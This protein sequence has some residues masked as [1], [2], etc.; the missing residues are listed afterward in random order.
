MNNIVIVDH[1]GLFIY[2]DIG[3]R[4]FYH[5]VTILWHSN[6]YKNWRQYFMHGDDYF[7]YLLGDPSYMGEE[8]FIMQKIGWH[9]LV[10][11]DDH[12]VMRAYNKTHVGFKV[13]V[14]RGIGGLKRKWRCLMKKFNW[15]KPKYAH[16]FW[17]IVLLTNV[18]HKKHMD[19]IY[20]VFGDLIV[21]PTE[22][23]WVGDF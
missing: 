10:L 8:M 1:H 22:H 2:I 21:N 15:T 13:Q 4:G 9:E 3:Y 19:L 17:A 7:E 11:D 14:E 18:L 5:D 20:K 16:L 23:G 6:V 12:V